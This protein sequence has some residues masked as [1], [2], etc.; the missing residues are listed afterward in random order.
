[1]PEMLP[2]IE[3]FLAVAVFPTALAGVGSHL[4]TLAISDHK[5]RLKVVI[6]VWVLAGFTMLLA[7]LQQIGAYQSDKK[8]DAEQAAMQTQLKDSA[9]GQAQMQG[10]MQ[11]K[12]DTIG[13]IV[14]G[15]E[16][17]NCGGTRLQFRN[18]SGQRVNRPLFKMAEKTYFS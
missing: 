5:R 2:Y 6:F 15:I 14:E 7:A 16:S 13:S 4:A 3:T 8:H 17:G 18:C 9:I 1:M 11:G 10:Q 12:L